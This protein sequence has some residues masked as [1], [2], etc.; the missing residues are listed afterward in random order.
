[1]RE[2]RRPPTARDEVLEALAQAEGSMTAREIAALIERPSP[3]VAVVLS[4]L[5]I[6]G[7]AKKVGTVQ[8]GFN[9]ANLWVGVEICAECERPHYTGPGETPAFAGYCECGR[10]DD[11]HGYG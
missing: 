9:V 1:M 11:F 2:F 3:T 10:H 8:R 6:D 5:A 4:G 7:L